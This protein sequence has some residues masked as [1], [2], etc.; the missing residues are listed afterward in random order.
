MIRSMTGFG[1]SGRRIPGFRMLVEVRSVN[2]RYA[3]TSVKINREWLSLEDG[4]KKLVARDIKRGRADVYVTVEPD[5]QSGKKLVIDWDLA[6][7]YMEA[8]NQLKVKF[9]LT[10]EPRLEDLLK[11]PELLHPGESALGEPAFPEQELMT[12]VEEAATQLSAMRVAEGAHLHED[13]V[14]RL[15]V[16]DG[17]LTEMKGMAAEVVADYSRKLAARIQELLPRDA[18]MDTGRL[19]Q[20]TALMADRCNIDEELTRLASHLAQF[21]GLLDAEEPVGRK[22]DFLIQEM[23]REVNTIGSKANRYELSKLVVELKAEL[24]KIREQVQNIE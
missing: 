7:A 10:D 24:E 9:G 23:N 19:E 14:R 5:G 18:V 1:Q 4:I 22:L 3:E 12:C 8:A 16:L 17:H 21:S 11:V 13:L 15:A 20:E 6:S 2:H